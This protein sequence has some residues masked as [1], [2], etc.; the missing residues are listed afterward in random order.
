MPGWE[1]EK[2]GSPGGGRLW[3]E[4]WLCLLSTLGWEALG[5]RGPAGRR[6]RLDGEEVGWV[7]IRNSGKMRSRRRGGEG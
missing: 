7:K 5:R 3:G 4:G 1:R 6:G 2:G